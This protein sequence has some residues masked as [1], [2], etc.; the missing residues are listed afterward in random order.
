LIKIGTL[1][2][3]DPSIVDRQFVPTFGADQ[4]RKRPSLRAF[5]EHSK[6]RGSRRMGPKFLRSTGWLSTVV[7]RGSNPFRTYKKLL[8]IAAGCRCGF[9]AGIGE[10]QLICLHTAAAFGSSWRFRDSDVEAR[11]ARKRSSPNGL[12]RDCRTYWRRTHACCGLSLI[13]VWR[14]RPPRTEPRPAAFVPGR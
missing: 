7:G 4:R 5:R 9:T 3:P 6:R 11:V 8:A 2:V 14:R 10:V 1:R 12:G 13:S